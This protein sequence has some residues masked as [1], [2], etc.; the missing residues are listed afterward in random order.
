MKRYSGFGWLELVVGILLLLLGGLVFFKPSLALN[1]MIFAYGIAA[2]IM[3]I[4]DIV[5]YIQIERFIGFGPVLCLITGVLSVMSGVMLLV[6]PQSGVIILSV[7]FP[8]WFIAHFI[9][10]LVH[11]NHIRYVR[12]FLTLAALRIAA[13]IYLVLLGIDSIVMAFSEMGK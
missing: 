3:G 4:A 1:S 9:S 12:P 10:R 7:L 5:L 11:L 2:M 8:I 13:A 6:Y